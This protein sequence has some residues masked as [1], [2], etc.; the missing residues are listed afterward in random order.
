MSDTRQFG[1]FTSTAFVVGT[2][3]GTGI[4]LKPSLVCSL[5]P[6]RWHNLGLWL[7]AGLFTL[8]GAWVYS[9]LARAWPRAGG[10]FIYLRECYGN[11]W[12]AL[13]MSADL[14]LGRPAAVGALAAGLG[15]IWGLGPEP[16]LWLA[17]GA[18]ALVGATQSLGRRVTGRLQLGITVLQLVPLLALLSV[19][20]FSPKTSPAGPVGG[21]T[22]WASAFL[23]ILWA[24]DGWYNITILAGEVKEPQKMRLYL[25]GGVGAVIALYLTLNALLLWKIPVSQ[26]AAQGVAF[27]ELL[28]LGSEQVGGALKLA[29]TLALWGTLNGVLACGPRMVS[30]GVEQG[31]LPKALGTEPGTPRATLAFTG[32]C[33]GG[34]LLA[35][36]LPLRFGLF[37]AL[38]E[39]TAVV[40]TLLSALT[41][42]CV[43]RSA[44]PEAPERTTQL[45]ALA[46]L[47]VALGLVG[48]L[49]AERPWLASGGILS[50]LGLGTGLWALGSR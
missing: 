21:P 12:A 48:L 40:V 29:L 10:A 28:P 5:A 15:E 3:V 34:L 7:V 31:L 17:L 4:Y 25:V 46:Y 30:A 6:N 36:A 23:A 19:G 41:V 43:F 47:M 13:L 14:F 20:L 2:V 38:S 11:W 16:T 32:L 18:V 22:M 37:D 45:A 26:A 42:S 44:Y 35:S 39:F 24:Y 8:C 49:V 27:L 50:V 1:P 9:E 33:L